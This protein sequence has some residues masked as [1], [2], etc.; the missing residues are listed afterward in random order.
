MPVYTG[1]QVFLRIVDMHSAQIGKTDHFIEVA[2]GFGKAL[3]RFNIITG[4]QRMSRVDTDTDARFIFYPIDD[5]CY[6]FECISQVCTLSGR[7]L[8][9]GTDTCGLVQRPVN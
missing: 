1:R 8:Y 3:F 2:E 9:N 6:L 5:G 4:S 7:I